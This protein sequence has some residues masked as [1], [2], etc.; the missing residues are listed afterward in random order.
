MITSTGYHL[1]VQCDNTRLKMLIL[2][3]SRGNVQHFVGSL[4]IEQKIHV[5][6]KISDVCAP[7]FTR[8]ATSSSRTGSVASGK[9]KGNTCTG[10]SI[11]G[12]SSSTGVYTTVAAL[13]LCPVGPIFFNIHI[14]VLIQVLT[15]RCRSDNQ[16]KYLQSHFFT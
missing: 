14:Y 12:S 5:G 7:E 16:I 11:R 3:R 15:F 13:V 6:G 4:G 1:Q 2:Q 8:Y 10:K 9:T